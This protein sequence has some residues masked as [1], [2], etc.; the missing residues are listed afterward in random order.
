MLRVERAAELRLIAS[1]RTTLPSESTIWSTW[2]AFRGVP[3]P[4]TVVYWTTPGS[5]PRSHASPSNFEASEAPPPPPPQPELI[6]GESGTPGVSAKNRFL[7]FELPGGSPPSLAVRVTFVDAPPPYDL[8]NGSS[9]WVD[10]PFEVPSCFGLCGPGPPPP[11][12]MMATL[13]C[14]NPTYRDW[15]DVGIVHV[16]HEG[17]VPGGTYRVEAVGVEFPLIFS[18][19]LEMTTAKFGDTV[20]SCSA[21]G[22]TPP[23]EDVGIIDALAILGRFASV[24]GSISLPRADLEPACVDFAINIS[25]VLHSLKGFSGVPYPFTP[26]AADPCDAT[27]SP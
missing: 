3:V 25:D 10:E 6:L 16:Y 4:H 21:L 11:P 27:C 5:D 13:R 1:V 2:E 9:M 22:C 8:W 15:G 23:D 19:P 24:P 14:G 7:S 12:Y 18:D 26:S 20:E 17:I